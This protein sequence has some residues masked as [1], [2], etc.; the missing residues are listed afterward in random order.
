MRHWS[1]HTH[2]TQADFRISGDTLPSAIEDHFGTIARQ[3]GVGTAAGYQLQSVEL[4]PE[5][6][7]T[8]AYLR[9]RAKGMHLDTVL[10]EVKLT[11]VLVLG[12][13]P[14]DLDGPHQFPAR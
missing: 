9:I 1:I 7:G 8:R 3:A 10:P 6:N 14:G 13:Q 12:L 11:E 5:G 2:S 4:V